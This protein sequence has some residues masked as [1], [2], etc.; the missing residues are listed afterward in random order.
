MGAYLY[1]GT[2]PLGD[3]SSDIL[4]GDYEGLI[5]ISL[6]LAHIHE[7][8]QTTWPIDSFV[9][10]KIEIID[11]ET[12]GFI[13]DTGFISP[14]GTYDG[15]IETVIPRRN[16]TTSPKARYYYHRC[17]SIC[18]NARNCSG[19]NGRIPGSPNKKRISGY[20]GRKT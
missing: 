14:A 15:S 3:N 10:T 13:Y 6:D 17:N 4:T 18:P 7:Q 20:G 8:L 19:F 5:D 12:N 9:G 11:G 1:N 16:S 2:S